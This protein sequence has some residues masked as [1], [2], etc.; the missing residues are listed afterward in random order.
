MWLALRR[1]GY[2]SA[3]RLLRAYSLI[4]HPSLTGVKC[5]LCHEGRVLLVRHTY[6]PAGWSLPGGVARLGERPERAARRELREELGIEVAELR[7]LGEIEL[8]V[9]GRRDR[10]HC[11][12]AEL[13]CSALRPARAEIAAVRW[14]ERE[15][16][17]E[18]LS[19]YTREILALL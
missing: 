18:P 17:P 10:V 13:G 8:S 11:F 19:P 9:D 16:L 14:C 6:G 2:R 4:A 15:R 1:L 7:E 3:Y 12:A 5:A